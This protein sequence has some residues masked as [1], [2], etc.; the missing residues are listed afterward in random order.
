MAK[1]K[2][3]LPIDISGE[4][5]VAENVAEAVVSENI[6]EEDTVAVEPEAPVVTTL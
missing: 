4:A 2:A 6:V 1:F 3:E 5:V